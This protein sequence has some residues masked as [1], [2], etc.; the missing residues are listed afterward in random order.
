MASVD[1]ETALSADLSRAL[2]ALDLPPAAGLPELDLE[3]A[4]LPDLADFS[5][6]E[7]ALSCSLGDLDI[8]LPACA[9]LS[10]TL[11]PLPS[12]RPATPSDSTVSASS[13][14]GVPATSNPSVSA[15]STPAPIP[16]PTPCCAAAQAALDETAARL[17]SAGAE[18]AALRARVAQLVRENRALR[19][20]LD[21]ANQANQTAAAQ[22]AAARAGAVAPAGANPMLMGLA[23]ISADVAAGISAAMHPPPPAGKKRKRAAARKTLACVVLMCGF[24]F[25]SPGSVLNP[26][27]RTDAN[28]PAVWRPSTGPRP[29]GN[30]LTV[31]PPVRP[32]HCLRTLEQLAPPAAEEAV[33]ADAGPAVVPPPPKAAKREPVV[34]GGAVERATVVTAPSDARTQQEFSYVMCRNSSA[35]VE[36]AGDCARRQAD[37]KACE[38]SQTISLIMPAN[39][40]D[41]DGEPADPDGDYAEV[42]CS[43]VSV[44]RVPGSA[45]GGPRAASGVAAARQAMSVSGGVGHVIASVPDL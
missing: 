6:V 28:L 39:A 30:R 21:A 8:L 38:A 12:P 29:A 37:G 43:V 45:A 22:T 26:S 27:D 33:K 16:G 20:S 7:E 10:G 18:S 5:P 9:P 19:A 41:P 13:S 42:L 40:L 32:S 11:S 35:M 3:D 2:R 25:G 34:V 17:T 24:F 4:G 1:A 31:P 15:A 23:Q 36:H 44:A 14:L